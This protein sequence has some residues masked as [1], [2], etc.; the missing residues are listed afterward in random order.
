MPLIHENR[1]GTPQRGSLPN[2]YGSLGKY[3]VHRINRTPPHLPHYD[4]LSNRWTFLE[5]WT[6]AADSDVNLPLVKLYLEENGPAG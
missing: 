1:S 2:Y 3:T 4:L 5:T 6:G